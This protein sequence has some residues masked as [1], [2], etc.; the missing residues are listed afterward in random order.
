MYATK[1]YITSRPNLM[2]RA[3]E[4]GL[5]DA[6]DLG[7]VVNNTVYGLK[8]NN[9]TVNGGP[10]IE[11]TP[12]GMGMRFNGDTYAQ[13]I[14]LANAITL[15]GSNFTVCAWIRPSTNAFAGYR[16]IMSWWN[17]AA[18]AFEVAY[19]T[20]TKKLATFNAGW[21]ESSSTNL[22]EKCVLASFRWDGSRHYMYVNDVEVYNAVMAAPT[23]G[24]TPYVG[25]RRGALFAA[26]TFNG[27]ILQVHVY[28]RFL[29]DQ[30][31]KNNY[32]KA[33]TA[34]WRTEYGPAVS[35]ADEGGVIGNYLSGTPFQFGDTTVRARVEVDNING[36]SNCKV[37]ANRTALGTL[38]LNTSVMSQNTTEAAFGTWK[39]PFKIPAASIFYWM[40][41]A[42]VVGAWNAAGQNGYRVTFDGTTGTISLH[43]ITAGAVAATLYV[44]AAAA[45]TA[46]TWF[47]Y[48]LSRTTAGVFTGKV[49][50]MPHNATGGGSNP[51]A[52]DVTHTTAAYHLYQNTTAVGAAWGYSDKSGGNANVKQVISI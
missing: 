24:L 27:D 40:P 34:L 9:G 7:N 23:I 42:S 20:D 14:A 16:R 13:W 26:S 38:V 19:R 18:D 11:K 44:S 6:W 12:V 30:E 52:A 47:E 29:S 22:D 46:A 35:S 2:P 10:G 45:F 5:V 28:N 32:L 48:A 3:D 49:N 8:G 17:G 51:S 36:V 4:E 31:I 39:C 15:T 1:P 50:Q 33:K 43:R 37:L 41:I 25:S 21:V